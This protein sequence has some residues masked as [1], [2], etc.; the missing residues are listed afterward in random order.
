MSYL[1]R[2]GFSGSSG[3]GGG[4][5]PIFFLPIFIRPHVSK[6]LWLRPDLLPGLCRVC[7]AGFCCQRG[8][9]VVH[10]Q[11]LLQRH[12]LKHQQTS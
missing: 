7:L 6:S 12:V 2:F 3:G 10:L 9:I 8:A 1:G 4:S 5:D 11:Q